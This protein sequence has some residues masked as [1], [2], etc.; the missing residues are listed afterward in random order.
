MIKLL[1]S[2]HTRYSFMMVYTLHQCFSNFLRRIFQQQLAVGRSLN[3]VFCPGGCGERFC[4]RSV[5]AY[6][7]E[8]DTLP[9]S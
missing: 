2:K 3:D 5:T 6:S 1:Q 9:L 4:P 8:A 7:W